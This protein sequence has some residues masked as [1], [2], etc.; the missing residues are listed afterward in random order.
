MMWP[1]LGTMHGVAP[2]M[3]ASAIALLIAGLYGQAFEMRK[4]R[5][6]QTDGSSHI[7][8]FLDKR[9]WKWYAMIAVSLVLFAIS[10]AP[11]SLH[12]PRTY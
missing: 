11:I 10:F 4:I 12:I 8:T 3:T 6:L 2:I 1:A 9:N 7:A 5:S